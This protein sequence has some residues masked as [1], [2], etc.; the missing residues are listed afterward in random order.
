VVASSTFSANRAPHGAVARVYDAASMFESFNSTFEGNTV[1]G[2]GGVFAVAAE[3]V[4]AAATGA[5]AA[6]GWATNAGRRLAAE[7][8][9]V[10][11]RVSGAS[12]RLEPPLTPRS[13]DLE[14]RA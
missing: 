4:G 7:V 6:G 8:A 10:G 13:P 12:P 14:C 5:A 11:P 3:A 9:T 1:S 2:D